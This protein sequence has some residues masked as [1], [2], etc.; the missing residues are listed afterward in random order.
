MKNNRFPTIKRWLDDFFSIHF[1]TFFLL[2][3]IYYMPVL[4]YQTTEMPLRHKVP[5]AVVLP[6]LYYSLQ[7]IY[8]SYDEGLHDAYVG[9]EKPLNFVGKLRF[10]L[11]QKRLYIEHAAVAVLYLIL[12]LKWIFRAIADLFF[13]G[14]T[15]WTTKWTLFLPLLAL[16]FL[17]TVAARLRVIRRWHAWEFQDKKIWENQTESKRDKARDKEAIAAASLY[18]V[19]GILFAVFISV[20]IG[21]APLA[22]RILKNPA[23]YGTLLFL[24]GLILFFRWGRALIKRISFMAKLKKVCREEKYNIRSVRRPYLSLFFL[25]KG[26]NFTIER[27]DKCYSCKMIGAFRKRSPMSILPGGYAK[28]IHA[29]YIRR[30]VGELFRYVKTVKFGWESPERKILIINPTSSTLQTERNGQTYL[31]DNGFTVGEYK[32]YTGSAFLNAL[33][34]DTLEK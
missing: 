18:A 27:R 1:V 11:T 31:I 17:L 16:F 9:L 25:P 29:F 34:L 33:H 28:L 19:V 20:F 26:A 32:I 22:W 30:G 8:A 7:R 12:P 21:L 15:G 24:I 13:A 4:V 2:A 5:S 10:I 3:C 23:V 14:D 6:F